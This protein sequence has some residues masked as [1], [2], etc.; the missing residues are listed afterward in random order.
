MKYIIAFLVVLLAGCGGSPSLTSEVALDRYNAIKELELDSAEKILLIT[1]FVSDNS[2]L[3][4]LGVV[5]KFYEVKQ[6][7]YL[8]KLAPLLDDSAWEVRRETAKLF[9]IKKHYNYFDKLKNISV[10][11]ESDLVRAEIVKNV[12]QFDDKRKDI[13]LFLND[14]VNDRSP[15]I[16]HYAAKQ[17]QLIK[18]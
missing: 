8:D 16:R 4:R 1:G 6:F 14:L 9:C 15:V 3:V 17:L 18:Q 10:T 13:F 2:K 5:E 12:L 11:D 7:E